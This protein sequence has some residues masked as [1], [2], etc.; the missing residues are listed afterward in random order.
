MQELVDADPGVVVSEVEPIEAAHGM[1]D[2]RLVV[3]RAGDVAGDELGLAAGGADR[4][5]GLLAARPRAL[6]V[7]DE[8][9]R[10]LRREAHGAGAA[11]ATRG[12]GD[13]PHLPVHQASHGASLSSSARMTS[14]AELSGRDPH[15]GGTD[16]GD[17]LR[18]VD[19][20][21]ARGRCAS[22]RC[23]TPPRNACRVSFR[24]RAEMEAERARPLADKHR[25]E[26]A[27]G[28]LTERFLASPRTG[29]HL[30]EAMLEPTPEALELIG[31]VPRHRCSSTSARCR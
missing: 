13:E 24:R 26:L 8:D 18:R 19:R 9:R 1:G 10:A 5:H 20:R 30:L 7:G 6:E 21:L 15:A 31:D 12:S 17:A 29:R 28:L 16:A 22:S 14:T 4:L 23:C 2:E 27:Q 3:G 25:L 11:D